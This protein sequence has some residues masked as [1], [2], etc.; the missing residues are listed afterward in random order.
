MRMNIGNILFTS[1]FLLIFA[2]FPLPYFYYQILRVVVSSVA[3]FTSIKFHQSKLFAWSFIFLS[4]A[5]VFNP[6][7]PLNMVKSS[8]VVIDLISAILF[9]MAAHS[10]REKGS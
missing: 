4:I 5:L 6:F 9:F 7:F 2:L 1:G 8:W 10:V 3:I